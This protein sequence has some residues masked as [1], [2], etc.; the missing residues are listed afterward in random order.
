[1]TGG[2]W[3]HRLQRIP[4]DPLAGDKYCD[5]GRHCPGTVT[6]L[7]TYAYTTGRGGHIARRRVYMCDTHAERFRAKYGGVS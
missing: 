1:M 4:V 2:S 7:G 5:I 3:G 6:H